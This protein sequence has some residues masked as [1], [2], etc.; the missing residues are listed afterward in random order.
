MVTR[1]EVFSTL[2]KARPCPRAGQKCRTPWAGQRAG[3]GQ[4]AGR[5]MEWP[6][7]SW[8]PSRLHH[9][10]HFACAKRSNLEAKTGKKKK[11][12]YFRKAD[13][14]ISF[15]P[16]PQPRHSSVLRARVRGGLPCGGT[17]CKKH[18]HDTNVLLNEQRLHYLHCTVTQSNVA[19]S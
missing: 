6:P 13:L 17:C 9:L 18:G 15:P 19:V 16:S 5:H 4:E 8:Y 7:S 12:I 1:A 14:N 3:A 11:A 10:A 2:P